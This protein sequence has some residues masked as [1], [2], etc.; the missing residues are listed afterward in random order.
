MTEPAIL[1]FTLVVLLIVLTIW[2]V[3]GHVLWQMAAWTIRQMLGPVALSVLL[4]AYLN[5]DR[6][7]ED[8]MTGVSYLSLVTVYAS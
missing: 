8:Q 2:A 7:G 4:A 1:L 6:L 3:I 5:E